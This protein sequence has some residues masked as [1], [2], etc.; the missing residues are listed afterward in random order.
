MA[1]TNNPFRYRNTRIFSGLSGAAIAVC[2]LLSREATTGK[3]I[4]CA[5]GA[6]PIGVSPWAAAAAN[7]SLDYHKG[8]ICTV[9]TDGSAAVGD[10]VKADAGGLGKGIK[11]T[12]PGIQTAGVLIQLDT[13]TN[14]GEVELYF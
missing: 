3:L 7:E 12:S 2:R 8:G 14:I 11:D 9:E 5:S 13:V 4:P 6:R 10:S 1:N